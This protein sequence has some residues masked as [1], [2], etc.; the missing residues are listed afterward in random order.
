[1]PQPI[2]M[3]RN[4]V[5]K[6]D[7][8][9][10]DSVYKNQWALQRIGIKG[11][12]PAGSFREKSW[13]VIAG[14]LDAGTGYFHPNLSGE[15]ALNA[16]EMGLDALGRDKCSNGLDADGDRYVDTWRG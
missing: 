13:W 5:Y 4:N 15:I 9:P 3:L 6:I 7:Q 2:R 12:W 16:G 8:I 14:V 11:L 10:N 1:V